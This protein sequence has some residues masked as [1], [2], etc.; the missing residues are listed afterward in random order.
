MGK[1]PIKEEFIINQKIVSGLTPGQCNALA[2]S[3]EENYH[4]L[5]ETWELTKLSSEQKK[6]LE[7]LEIRIK[8]YRAYYEQNL[9]SL[10][11]E[12]Q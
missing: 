12:K 2:N 1:E 6:Y 8:N 5:K 4:K 9:P 11:K 10:I 3:I 7:A